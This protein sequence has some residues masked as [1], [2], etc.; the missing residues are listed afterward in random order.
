MK[1][2]TENMRSLL[3]KV[4]ESQNLNEGYYFNNTGKYEDKA[5]ELGK[6]VPAMGQADT[7]RGEVWRAAS[8]IYHDYYNNGFGNQWQAPLSFLD[9]YSKMDPAI[10]DFLSLYANGNVHSGA[11]RSNDDRYLEKMID[12]AIMSIETIPSDMPAR[13][14]MW[15]TDYSHLDL[16]PEDYDDY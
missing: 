16:A 14:D 6:L 10:L 1:T 9:R 13:N 2:L 7:Q 4:T 11:G 5:K 3:N 12:D 15:D 8:K